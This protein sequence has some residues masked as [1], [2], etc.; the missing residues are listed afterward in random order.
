M[1]NRSL[2]SLF[3]FPLALAVALPLSM[4]TVACGGD[5]D[6]DG[7]T[8]VNCDDSTLTYANFGEQFFTSFCTDC[9][10][11]DAVV[12]QS[13]SLDSYDA[14]SAQA[15]RANARAGIGLTM[16]PTEPRPSAQERADLA[17]WVECGAPQ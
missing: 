1:K 4:T 7:G 9:H 17:E 6:D 3:S 5:D 16:P 10:A 15:D 12:S 11:P 8:G 2:S 13:P 14:V